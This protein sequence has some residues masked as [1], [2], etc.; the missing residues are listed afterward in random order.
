VV[1]DAIKMTRLLVVSRDSEVLRPLLS[2]MESN[3]WQLEIVAN[4]WEAMDR[5]QS[6]VTLDLLLLDLAEGDSED[7]HML[8]WLRRLRPA[9]P[10]ILIG[11]ADDG[12]RKQESV[13]MGARDFLIRPIDD[14]HLEIAIQSNLS[15][16]LA[17]D[18]MDITSD[19]VEPVG[20]GSFF[21][22]I[23]SVMRVL[24][25]QVASLAEAN[26]PV[27][28]L[29]ESG[30][31]KGTT[32]RL[33]H[34]LSV[35]SG[36]EFAK[37]NCAALPSDLL[38]RELFGYV[39]TSAT[40]TSPTKLG[41]LELC[42]KGTILLDEIIEMPLDLQCKL[43]QVLRNKRFTKPGSSSSIEIDVRILATSPTNM[44]REIAE[45]RLLPRSLR[46]LEA[47]YNSRA[48]TSRAWGGTPVPVA[49]FHAHACQEVWP[50]ATGLFS[51]HS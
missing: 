7:F 8:R 31:G 10:I 48:S 51:G 12:D 16:A 32:A 38:E 43:L 26:E 21:I 50:L 45:H 19:D 23:S 42:A 46:L 25:S 29:G 35:R 27:L 2:M 49:P 18:G 1:T 9:L 4:A 13:R 6:G 34:K 33:V 41:K 20:D 37:V 24:R 40:A 5:M 28:I 22:G 11:H 30:T 44:E 39:R 17:A 47:L 15:T 14:R 36:F 3:C